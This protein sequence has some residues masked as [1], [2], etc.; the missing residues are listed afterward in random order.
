MVGLG[1]GAFLVDINSM[2]EILSVA[3]LWALATLV[4]LVSMVPLATMELVVDLVRMALVVELL[5]VP[6]ATLALLVALLAVVHLSAFVEDLLEDVRGW[7]SLAILGILMS[8]LAHRLRILT[9]CATFP[10]HMRLLHWNNKFARCAFSW[11]PSNQPNP[12]PRGTTTRRSLRSNHG[13][14][15]GSWGPSN[16]SNPHPRDTSTRRILRSDDGSVTGIATTRSPRWTIHGV[17][18]GSTK[19]L[20]KKAIRLSEEPHHL[21]RSSFILFQ[22]VAPS[23]RDLT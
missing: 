5:N 2:V 16:Q 18:G 20:R 14:A 1:I 4:H 6:L 22:K 13:S 21:L 7:A 3:P 15:T 11:G 23:E 9:C 19:A 17:A 8:V 10:I 12:H